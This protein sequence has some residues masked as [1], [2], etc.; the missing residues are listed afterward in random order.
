MRKT[1][2]LLLVVL[3]LG[4]VA[5][6]FTSTRSQS[7]STLESQ[8][9]FAIPDTA[10]VGKIFMADGSGR[11]ITLTR[12]ESGWSVNGK[13]RAR[14]DAVHTLLKT[15][16]NVYIQRPVP[17]EAQEEVVRQ[18]AGAAKKVEIYDR[19]GNW[20]KTWFVGPGT[21]DKKGTYM[22]LETPKWGRAEE[23]FIL[24]MRGFIGMLD[25]RFFL[26]ENEWRSVGVWRYP[27][28][29]IS[30]VKVEYPAQT[31]QSFRITF[32]G[33]N[34]IKFF[35]GVGDE[36]LP[37]DSTLVKD[38]LLNFKLA[39]FEN[40]KTG[41]PES[42]VDS[43]LASTPFQIIT[44]RDQNRETKVRLWHKVAP[45]G[46]YEEDG[47]TIAEFDL[48]YVYAATEA[49]ELARAQRFIWDKFRAPREIFIKK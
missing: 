7:A 26:D 4:A 9:D 35:E 44:L 24:D 47:E 11:S 13:Y 18:L 34:D 31:E 48:E 22:V 49:G 37:F 14:E 41:L 28:L 27:D 1:G 42:T 3:G 20:I 38:Y 39:S 5:L 33:G 46:R 32:D 30:E 36:S 15:F 40:Y 29:T 16:K 21:M 6:Y 45:E 8:T 17:K 19:E 2:I 23:P 12:T 43:I 10:A 25:T